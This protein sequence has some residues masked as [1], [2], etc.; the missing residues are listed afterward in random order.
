MRVLL[1]EDNDSLRSLFAHMLRGRGCEVHEVADGQQ[2]LDALARFTPDLVLT[3]LMMPVLDGFELM[4]RLRALPDLRSVPIV[5][6][7]ALNSADAEREARRAGAAD[8]LPKPI[9]ARTLLDRVGRYG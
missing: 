3:D 7:T 8:F 5:A 9:A 4:R 1:V 6:M 2:A